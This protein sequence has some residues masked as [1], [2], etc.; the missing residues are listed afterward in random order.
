MNIGL[1]ITI[2]SLVY[3]VMI[4]VIYFSK[5]RIDLLENEV[6]VFIL[7]S[8][9]I[10]FIINILAFLVDI[11]FAELIPLRIILLKL[12]YIYLITLIISVSL[13]IVISS[14]EKI[15]DKKL[16]ALKNLSIPIGIFSV[17]AFIINFAL[18]LHI[19]NDGLLSGPNLIYIYIFILFGVI[20]WAIYL[21]INFRKIDRR[22]YIPVII[23]IICLI[24]VIL[25][26]IKF[27]KILLEPAVITFSLIVMYFTI[28]NP[29]LK[30]LEELRI[31]KEQAEKS[32]RA[33]SDFLSSMS[34]EIRTP[35][36]AIVGLSQDVLDYQREVPNEVREDLKD[37]LNASE[38]LLE[39]V[40]NILDISKIE[41]DKLELIEEIYNPRKEFL[42]VAELIS[43]RIEEKGLGFEV[44][45]SKELPKIL[46]GDKVHIKV[47]LNNLLSNAFKYTDAG[48]IKF[49]V[50]CINEPNIAHLTIV[51]SDTGKGIK[52]DG[53]DKLFD[54]FERLDVE[55]NSVIEGTGLGLA[56]TKRLVEMMNGSIEVK[57]TFG[58][59]TSFIVK[60]DQK[61]EKE[62]TMQNEPYDDLELPILKDTT[63]YPRRRVLIV[64]DNKLNIKVLKKAIENYDFV[65][66][67]AYDGNSCIEKVDKNGHYDLIFMDIMM[68]NMGGEEALSILKK[69]D[70]FITPVIAVTADAIEGSK[71]KYL[72]EGFSSYISKPFSREEIKQ[73]IEQFLK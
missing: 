47:I 68:P 18:P 8:T 52:E 72:E 60:I 13:Y 48:K 71:N 46:F 57:S 70:G 45:I 32:N 51:V 44:D 40:G 53:L 10:G 35:L 29:D 66:D 49:I 21:S 67:E 24:P 16:A 62:I 30:A 6:Y 65:I 7:I 17:I 34:H 11:Y 31:A 43:K 22:K 50:D 58:E 42:N 5:E 39:I 2:F 25:L 15:K 59:G 23:F 64:D 61:I 4:T 63:V 56:I 12:Y 1:A 73:K 33:K 20:F 37:I 3:I 19:D 28:E 38:I 26:E 55:K 14:I 27:P 41:R 9:I 69:R 54:K 36:N